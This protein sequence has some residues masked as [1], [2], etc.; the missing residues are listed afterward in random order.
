MN[1]G[2]SKRNRIKFFLGLFKFAQDSLEKKAINEFGTTEL[3]EDAG[4]ILKNGRMLNFCEENFLDKFS[5]KRI[6]HNNI[7]KIIED[8][9]IPINESSK[10]FMEKTG[11]IRISLLRNFIFFEAYER[12]SGAQLQVIKQIIQSDEITLIGFLCM[13]EEKYLEY[14]Y[15]DSNNFKELFLNKINGL[16]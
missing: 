15:D 2:A 8:K 7:S 1:S 5:K 12:L 3:F 6:N 10:Y 4:F 9:D 14:N 11:A 16:K 13:P